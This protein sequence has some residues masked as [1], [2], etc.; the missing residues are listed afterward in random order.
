MHS[1]TR[2]DRIQDGVF[3]RKGE[4]PPPHFLF[5]LVNVRAGT[6]S[7]QAAAAVERVVDTLGRLR[8]DGEISD[9]QPQ[10]AGESAAKLPRDNFTFLVGYGARFF[11]PRRHDPPLT[12]AARP[13]FMTYLARDRGEFATIPWAVDVADEIDG[14]ADLCLQLNGETASAVNRAAVEVW[15]EVA[16]GGLPLQIAGFHSGFQRDDGRSWL[17]FHDGISN[18]ESSHRLPALEADADPEW[19]EGGTYLAFLRVAVDLVAWR[20]LTRAQ[21]EVIVGRD[22]LTGC[23]LERVDHTNGELVPVPLPGCPVG[24]GSKRLQRASFFDP[25]QRNDRLVESSHTHRANQSRA[26]PGPGSQRIFRQGYEF[27]A[28]IDE[29]GPRLGLNFVSFQKDLERLKSVLGL[30]GWLGDVNFGGPTRPEPGDPPQ[31]PLITLLAGGYYAVPPRA[32]PFP[33][34]GLFGKI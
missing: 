7:K 17:D 5:L 34:A 3:F 14:E 29:D 32:K 28:S 23:P 21:Q 11:D 26:A 27:L 2:K 15:K 6:P 24:D 12:E 20:E 19:M 10:E 1:A 8:R 30:E 16:D 13:E 25:P 33:G 22:K 18:I 4:R 31:V 9:L